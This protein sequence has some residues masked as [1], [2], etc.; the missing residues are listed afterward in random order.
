MMP[1]MLRQSDGPKKPAP[2]FGLGSAV[3]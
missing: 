2:D 3:R 1:Y